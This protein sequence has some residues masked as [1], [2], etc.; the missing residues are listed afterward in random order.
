MYKK[1]GGSLP[2]GQVQWVYRLYKNHGAF[3]KLS[4]TT[5]KIQIFSESR[6]EE[7]GNACPTQDDDGKWS[8]TNSGVGYRIRIPIGDFKD[9][10]DHV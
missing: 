4:T 2:V 1:V 6:F 10:Y 7:L 5:P 9:T 8:D 3:S